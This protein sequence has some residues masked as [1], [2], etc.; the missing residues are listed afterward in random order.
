MTTY[1]PAPVAIIPTDHGLIA[2][3]VT[4]NNPVVLTHGVTVAGV[5]LTCQADGQVHD[6]VLYLPDTLDYGYCIAAWRRNHGPVS[7]CQQSPCVDAFGPDLG[8]LTP[9]DVL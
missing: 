5:T 3:L 9:A 4:P 2:H 7:E 8:D 6:P 1:T